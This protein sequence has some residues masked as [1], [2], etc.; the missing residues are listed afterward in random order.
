MWGNKHPHHPQRF[1]CRRACGLS[2]QHSSAVTR[3][4]KH[5]FEMSPAARHGKAAGVLLQL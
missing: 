4:R 1:S 5:E 2:M 3:A